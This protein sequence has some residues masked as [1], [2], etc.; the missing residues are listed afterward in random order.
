MFKDEL[1]ALQK[2][3]NP[4][5]DT[6]YIVEEFKKAIKT[7]VK[8]GIGQND[9]IVSFDIVGGKIICRNPLEHDPT[10][11]IE[12]LSAV[13]KVFEKEGISMNWSYDRTNLNGKVAFMW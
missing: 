12:D 7:C 9:N 4:H 11:F 13:E 2:K 10:C 3:V 5:K 8:N 1:I 6:T